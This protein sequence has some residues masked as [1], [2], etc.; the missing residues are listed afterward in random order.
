MP[1]ISEKLVNVHR[2][3]TRLRNKFLKNKAETI[4]SVITSKE[5]SV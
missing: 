3:R 1:L 4:D 2:K 5:I